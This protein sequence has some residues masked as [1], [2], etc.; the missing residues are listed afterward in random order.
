MWMFV[1]VNTKYLFENLSSFHKGKLI[2]VE[3]KILLCSSK[4]DN[5][6]NL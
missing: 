4:T 2:E 6:K 3:K 1:G 5:N